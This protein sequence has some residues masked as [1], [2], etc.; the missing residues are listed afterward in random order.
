LRKIAFGSLGPFAIQ[1]QEL[2]KWHERREQAQKIQ[3]LVKTILNRIL[4][5]SSKPKKV[6]VRPLFSISGEM[7][8][9]LKKPEDKKI[10]EVEPVMESII[11]KKFGREPISKWIKDYTVDII[12]PEFYILAGKENVAIFCPDIETKLLMEFI[13]ALSHFPLSSIKRCHWCNQW[14]LQPGRKEKNFCS[15][16]HYFSWAQRERRKRLKEQTKKRTRKE[17]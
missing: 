2:I 17:D 15:T 12:R 9:V 10:K 8:K 16:R 14:F 13:S 3:Q 1:D 4:I 11:F 6:M 5:I 7:E